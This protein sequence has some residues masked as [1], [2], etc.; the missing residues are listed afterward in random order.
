MIIIALT[1]DS[2]GVGNN[3]AEETAVVLSMVVILILVLMMLSE[4]VSPM[5]V[6][7]TSKHQMVIIEE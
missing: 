1:L 5:D 4:W 6:M 2:V 3:Q 7:R